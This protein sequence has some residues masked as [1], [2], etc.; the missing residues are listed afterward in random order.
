MHAER[1]SEEGVCRIR[2]R[3]QHRQSAIELAFWMRL[4]EDVEVGIAVGRVG[5]VD[6]DLAELP[7]RVRVVTL[8]E[9]V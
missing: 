9:A 2:P 7:F 5:T 6:A 4:Q 1:V 8:D 3:A